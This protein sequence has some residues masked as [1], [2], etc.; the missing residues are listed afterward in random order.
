MDEYLQLLYKKNE[1]ILELETEVASLR[2]KL[3][4][5]EEYILLITE[6]AM[7][8]VLSVEEVYWPDSD[9]TM[10]AIDRVMVRIGERKRNE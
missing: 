9:R 1:N 3:E 8:V 10:G 5:A 6:A 4:E 2:A 7:D